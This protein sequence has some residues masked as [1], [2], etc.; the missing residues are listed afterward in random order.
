[1]FDELQRRLK[2]LDQEKIVIP[3]ELDAEGFID[4]ECPSDRCRFQFKVLNEDWKN[5]CKDEAIY[6]PLCGHADPSN[7]W[8]T[9]QQLDN[10]RS[11]GTAYI[12]GVIGNAL[13]T[14]A[15]K[16]NRRQPKGGFFRMSLHA[17]GFH[18]GHIIVPVPAGETFVLKIACEKC[19]CRFGVVGS[20]F[21][22]PACGHTS[23]E[24]LF[25]DAIGKVY[26]K[27]D[28][29]PRIR[30]MLEQD[31]GRDQAEVTCRSTV[32]SC[33]SDCV[34]AFQRLAET[35]FDRRD[36]AEKPRRNCFQNL[37]EG[38]NLWKAEFGCAYDRWL[39]SDEL[40]ELDRF[41]Q[42]RHLLAHRE[43]LVDENYV[44]KSGD[45]SYTVGQRLVIKVADARRLAELVAKLGSGLKTSPD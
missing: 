1:M 10:V 8:M 27:L 7:A 13:K 25:D 29:I 20:A 39:I 41:F 12:S 35:I 42:Q 6:C 11:Q 3:V 16:F 18:T 40:A 36:S 9:Q 34:G 30:E 19:T 15:K 17:K 23:V 21:F 5:I 37:A 26:T 28:A 2:K 45:D 31:V 38:S 22:C 24:R 44:A 43:G 4:R 33:L 14:D 32:E